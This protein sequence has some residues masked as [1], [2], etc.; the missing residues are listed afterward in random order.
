MPSDLEN[1]L[2]EG[3]ISPAAAKLISNAIDN[4]AT[5]RLSIGRQLSDATPAERM[6]LI[7]S[8]T[9]RYVLTNLDYPI[10]SPFRERVNSTAGQFK[11]R[12]TKHPY[13]GSQPASASPT[14]KTGSVKA[15]RF[16]SVAAATADDVAQSEVTLN[17]KE[18]GGKHARLDPATGAVESVPISVEVEP[19]DYLEAS[20]EERPEGTVIRIRLKPQEFMRVQGVARVRVKDSLGATCLIENVATGQS[21]PAAFIWTG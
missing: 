16:M 11:P 8:D 10:D 5:G 13:D 2:I 20:V 19:K 18:R 15:G 9:R 7:D 12:N 3:G 4:A 1:S 14:L 21:V 17:I 6:R